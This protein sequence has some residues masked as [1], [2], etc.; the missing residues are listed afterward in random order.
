MGKRSDFEKVDKDFYPTPYEA[1]LPLVPF[2]PRK[3]FYFAEP[4]AGDGRL[5]DHMYTATNSASQCPFSC[6]LDPQGP[7]I[8]QK[9]ALHVNMND[10]AACDLIITNPP[11]SRDKK[12]G[13]ILHRM[14]EH[15]SDLK[16]TW[17]LFDA[18]WLFTKQATPFLDRCVAVVS[19]GRVKWIEGS[20]MTG[21]DNCQWALFRRDARE[22]TEGPVLFGKGCEAPS[23]EFVNRISSPYRLVLKEAA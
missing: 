13:F 22:V 17:L 6:D 3:R 11:W 5:I 7:G 15:F 19:I 2:L 10:V 23:D 20:K 8:L 18:D 16:P 12:S 4:A 21:K 1:V 9:N 14:I